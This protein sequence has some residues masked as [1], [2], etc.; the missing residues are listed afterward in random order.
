M[1]KL[2]CEMLPWQFTEINEIKYYKNV[3]KKKAHN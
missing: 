2:Q 3:Y 1:T